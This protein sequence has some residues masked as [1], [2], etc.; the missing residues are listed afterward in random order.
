M[1]SG[2]A[3][4]A[5]VSLSASLSTGDGNT[6]VSD[7]AVAPPDFLPLNFEVPMHVSDADTPSSLTK[8]LSGSTCST[9]NSAEA[10]ESTIPHVLAQTTS[11]DR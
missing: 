8:Y 5:P 2:L 10:L 6:G 11:P 4:A 7:K 9:P 3:P 1:T